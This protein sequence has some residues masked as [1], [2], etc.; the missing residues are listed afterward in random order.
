VPLDVLFCIGKRNLPHTGESEFGMSLIQVLSS[1]PG[2]SLLP[3]TWH[4]DS[5][6]L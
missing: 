1:V 4:F 5:P 6:D 2:T 3:L